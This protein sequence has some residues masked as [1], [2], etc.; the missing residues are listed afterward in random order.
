MKNIFGPQVEYAKLRL[1]Y[2]VAG[3]DRGFAANKAAVSEVAGVI[4]AL[5]AA[6]ATVDFQGAGT[7][8]LRAPL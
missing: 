1:M 2:C 8:Y 4:N 3:L 7:S 6:G 5:V